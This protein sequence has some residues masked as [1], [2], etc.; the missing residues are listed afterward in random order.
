MGSFVRMALKGAVTG[1]GRRNMLSSA[2]MTTARLTPGDPAPWFITP[3]PNNPRYHF[4]SVA[5]R[6][7]VLCFFGSA[8]NTAIAPM[9]AALRHRGDVF[10]DD[11]VSFFGGRAGPGEDRDERVAERSH[12]FRL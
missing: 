11:Q 9:L 8:G 6:Y 2:G 4:D 12:G 10:N 1:E 3:S 5:G 7:I